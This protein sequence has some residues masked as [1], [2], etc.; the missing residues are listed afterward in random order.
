MAEGKP[1]D[2]SDAEEK[3]LE[4]EKLDVDMDDVAE[5]LREQKI[6]IKLKTDKIIA[7]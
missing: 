6:E 2:K 7:M 4:E 5:L 3:L 1:D